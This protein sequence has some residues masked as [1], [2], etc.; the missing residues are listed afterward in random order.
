MRANPIVLQTDSSSTANGAVALQDGSLTITRPALSLNL[1]RPVR[2]QIEKEMLAA[3]FGMERFHT[4]VYNKQTII[5]KLLL[6]QFK[7]ANVNLTPER[8]QRNRRN[9]HCT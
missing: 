3:V 5:K 6:L 2:E 1:K 8:N 9:R 4:C 7:E